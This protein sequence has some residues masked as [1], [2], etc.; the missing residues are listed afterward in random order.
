MYFVLMAS[1]PGDHLRSIFPLSSL[2]LLILKTKG[3]FHKVK[4]TIKATV[5]KE[6]EVSLMEIIGP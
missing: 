1:F 3:P 4:G 5:C 6:V 2:T